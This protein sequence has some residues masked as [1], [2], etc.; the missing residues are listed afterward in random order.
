[1]ASLDIELCNELSKHVE[2]LTTTGKKELDEGI[3]KKIKKI[4]KISNEY[5]KQLYHLSMTQLNKDHSEVRYGAILLIN[6]I[7]I[8]SHVF[9]EMLLA[10]FQDFLELSVETDPDLPLPPPK[11]AAS[12]LKIKTLQLIQ[13]W[14]TKFGEDYKRL[15]LGYKYLKHCKKVD[16]DDARSRSIIQRQREEE[17]Q[18][19]RDQAIA[20]K[21]NKAKQ[22]LL[23]RSE[24]ISS[25]L[26]QVENCFRILLPHP[27]EF[28]TEHDFMQPSTSGVVSNKKNNPECTSSDLKTSCSLR[29]NSPEEIS[30]SIG[31]GVPET[32]RQHGLHDRKFNLTIEINKESASVVEENED[33]SPV[34]DNLRDLHSQLVSQYLPL[35]SKWA[36]VFTS[37]SNCTDSLKKAIDLKQMLE[38][39]INKFREL[40]IMPKIKCKDTNSNDGED[41]S[42]VDEGLVEV[43]EKEGYEPVIPVH[44]R[45]EYGL[46]VDLEK[47]KTIHETKALDEIEK[48]R[49]W[50]LKTQEDSVK[51]PTSRLS[52]LN[53]LCNKYKDILNDTKIASTPCETSDSENSAGK[54][55]MQ[56]SESNRKQKLLSEAPV[57]PFDIDLYHWEDEKLEAPVIHQFSGLHC[58]WQLK[59]DDDLNEAHAEEG[60]A[61]LRRRYIDFSGKFVPVKWSCRAPLPSGKLCP[62]KDR[63]KCPLHG[64]VVA[65]DE[66]GNPVNP[67]DAV[68]KTLDQPSTSKGT[69]PDWQDPELLR[70]I[71]AATGVNLKMPEKR[72]S[73]GKGSKGKSTK[74]PKYPGLTDVKKVENTVRKRLEKKVLNKN[75]VKRVSATLDALDRK[76]F[77]DKYGN[78]WNYAFQS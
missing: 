75:V 51:D 59:N 78:Q 73:K 34:I 64:P 8:R 26:T 74:K 19:R 68:G 21:V 18:R 3:I 60:V 5:V 35:V 76:R 50:D 36:K 38:G 11:A 70:D 27:E 52:T 69:V 54:S 33:T 45:K 15:N 7:F 41:D 55:T 48:R 31:A 57:L 32:L 20:D 29:D 61:A 44:K 16:F 42:E 71:E 10:E 6:E 46:D 47:I 4:C 37:G 58:F 72:K 39:S 2:A 49:R 53:V 13:E 12:D 17:E 67:E 9:R 14:N 63:Y 23:D 56:S 24:E 43:E 66:M 77:L 65:R 40:K 22:E 1:M 28:F 25:I 62:R 30:G